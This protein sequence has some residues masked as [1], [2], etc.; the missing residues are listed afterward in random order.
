MTTNKE[1]HLEVY[2]D[3]TLANNHYRLLRVTPRRA[4]D[5]HSCYVCFDSWKRERQA[6]GENRN[7]TEFKVIASGN[8]EWASRIGEHY[9]LR[10]V[11]EAHRLERIESDE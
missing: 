4:S 10:A 3:D 6:C 11:H 9:G 1:L 5:D 8:A 7:Y 2:W